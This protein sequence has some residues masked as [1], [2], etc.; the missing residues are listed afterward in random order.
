MKTVIFLNR[1]ILLFFLFN[2]THHIHHQSPI[3]PIS[4]PIDPY[5]FTLF[6]YDFYYTNNKSKID[7]LPVLLEK[8][9]GKEEFILQGIEKKYNIHIDRSLPISKH[10]DFASKEFIP[11][12]ALLVDLKIDYSTTT[13]YDNI[14]KCAHL[15]FFWFFRDYSLLNSFQ[16]MIKIICRK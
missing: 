9:K 14:S 3:L 12:L 1:S 6:L 10:Y 8:S 15:V 4:M 5:K 7:T 2:Y 16:R 11:E 13:I